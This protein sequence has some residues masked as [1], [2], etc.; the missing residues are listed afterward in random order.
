MSTSTTTFETISSTSGTRSTARKSFFARLI[1]ARTRRGARQV[2]FQ[3]ARMSDERLADLGFTA[4]QIAYIRT[5]G[6]IPAGFW[7]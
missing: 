4:E 7:R 2:G 6:R 3:M 5:N 1:E